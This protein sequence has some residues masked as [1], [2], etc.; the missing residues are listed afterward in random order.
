V[1]VF[2]E[3][4]CLQCQYVGRVSVYCVSMLGRGVSAVGRGVSAVSVFEEECLQ[5]QYVGRMSVYCV[6]MLER[7]V[8]AVSVCWEEE[9]LQGKNIVSHMPLH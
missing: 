7:G 2:W 1:S 5:C 4:E 6:S 9:C 3:E 8:S